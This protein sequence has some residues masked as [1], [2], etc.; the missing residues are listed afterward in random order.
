MSP[1]QSA[2]ARQPRDGEDHHIDGVL[3]HEQIFGQTGIVGARLDE[4]LHDVDRGGREC[5][6]V[7]Q[8]MHAETE[9]G[10]IHDRQALETAQGVLK[11]RA[12]T[13]NGDF[14]AL[15]RVEHDMP[16]RRARWSQLVSSR[17][18]HAHLRCQLQAKSGTRAREVCIGPP[19]HMAQIIMISM[20]CAGHDAL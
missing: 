16:P 7:G 1:L 8:R 11:F 6:E 9:R 19:S 5:E 17:H 13:Q 3:E 15:S 4:V 18:D 12:G 14:D 20:S 2:H 10:L